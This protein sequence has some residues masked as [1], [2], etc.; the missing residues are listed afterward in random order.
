M[1]ALSKMIPATI[2][3]GFLLGFSMGSRNSDMLHISHLLFANDTFILCG[4]NPNHIRYLC[5]LFLCF[6]V[7]FD[8]KINLAKS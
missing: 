2:D 7:V 3:G 1:E 6:E 8:L 5:A 4:A